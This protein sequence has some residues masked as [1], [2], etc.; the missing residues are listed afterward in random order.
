M[1]LISAI[2]FT[3]MIAVLLIAAGFVLI[4]DTPQIRTYSDAIRAMDD[5]GLAGFLAA[6]SDPEFNIVDGVYDPEKVTAE[7]W[8]AWLQTEVDVQC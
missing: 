5:A 1:N 3:G 4:A 8:Y 2:I 7:Q 6:L